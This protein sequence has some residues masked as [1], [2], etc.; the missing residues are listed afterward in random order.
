MFDCLPLNKRYSVDKK[1]ISYFVGKQRIFG[2]TSQNINKSVEAEKISLIK[3]IIYLT[4]QLFE[5]F[6]SVSDSLVPFRFEMCFFLFSRRLK[7]IDDLNSFLKQKINLK[8][9][10]SSWSK[11]W[12]LTYIQPRQDLWLFLLIK[13]YKNHTTLAY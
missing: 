5:S 11:R 10:F 6:G 1:M 12:F 2:N 13:H 3:P 4:I 9:S 8:R 7:I